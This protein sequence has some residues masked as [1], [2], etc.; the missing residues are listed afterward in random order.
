VNPEK[1]PDRDLSTKFTQ[2]VEPRSG[3]SLSTGQICN[4]K[5][6]AQDGLLRTLRDEYRTKANKELRILSP[7]LNNKQ[8]RRTCVRRPRARD[9]ILIVLFVLGLPI[10]RREA[11]EA[12]SLELCPLRVTLCRVSLRF[13]RK[14]RSRERPWGGTRSIHRDIGVRDHGDPFGS[15]VGPLGVPPLVGLRINLGRASFLAFGPA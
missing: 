1:T 11:S 10:T 7:P 2:G 15:L 4:S 8:Q 13:P 14:S 5:E 12:P 9:S 3:T 6:V